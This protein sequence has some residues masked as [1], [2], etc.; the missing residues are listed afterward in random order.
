MKILL[1][2][3]SPRRRELLGLLDVDF[4]IIEPRE[5]DEIY[6]DE[7]PAHE[8]APFLSALKASAYAGVPKD[9]EV[10]LTADTV[11]IC[12]GAILGK[13]HDRAAAIEMLKMLSDRTHH[14]VTGVTLMSAERQMTFS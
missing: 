7:L 2:S 6:P 1:A 14:V 5:I 11:V 8:V 4:T 13:P 3:N 10:V 9:D 12:G